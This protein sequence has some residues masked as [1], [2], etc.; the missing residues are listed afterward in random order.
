M[1]PCLD[2]L[3][4]V[5]GSCDALKEALGACR[6]AALPVVPVTTQRWVREA[7]HA[8]LVTVAPPAR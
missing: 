5:P 4:V 6:A 7:V 1:L 3:T 2:G 8:C